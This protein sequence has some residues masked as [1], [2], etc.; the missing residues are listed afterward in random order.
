MIQGC[1]MDNTKFGGKKMKMKR[2]VALLL[3]GIMSVTMLTG[4]G[5]GSP[6]TEAFGGK[7]EKEKVS[8]ALWG[9][10]LLENYLF[11]LILYYTIFI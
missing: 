5:D 2:T 4:C 9:N 1:D 7:E 11:S 3:A 8:V 10:Q 6:L